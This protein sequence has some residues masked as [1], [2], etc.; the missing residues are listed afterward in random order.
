MPN[1]IQLLL[2]SKY[3]LYVYRLRDFE[4]SVFQAGPIAGPG[5]PA[6]AER[7]G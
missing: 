3:E 7:K 1:R 6:L 4:S 2:E 5:K